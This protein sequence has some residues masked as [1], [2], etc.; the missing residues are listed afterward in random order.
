MCSAEG[1]AKLLGSR[2]LTYSLS[3]DGESLRIN[4]RFGS[5]KGGF[6]MSDL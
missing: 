6:Q 1:R 4:S 2:A 3:A 5:S